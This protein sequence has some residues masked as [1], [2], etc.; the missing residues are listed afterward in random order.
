MT[1]L[2]ITYTLAFSGHNDSFP[3]ESIEDKFYYYVCY[4]RV[5]TLSSKFVQGLQNEQLRDEIYCQV[6]NQCW[7]NQNPQAVER[8]WNLMAACLSAFPPSVK[9]CKYLI[10]YVIFF[11]YSYINYFVIVVSLFVN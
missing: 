6:V 3:V 2:K 11:K 9:L 8:G 4:R 5:L 10:K 7:N 1:I